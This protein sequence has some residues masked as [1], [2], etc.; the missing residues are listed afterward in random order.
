MRQRPFGDIAGT[1]FHVVNRAI[2][3]QLLFRDFGA[4]LAY[5]RLMA[6][7]LDR[8]P[9]DMFAFCLMPNHVHFLLRPTG[10]RDLVAFMQWLTS[11]HA[12]GVRRWSGTIGRGAV[13]QSRYWAS[14]VQKELYFCRVAR[15]IERNPVRASLVDRTHEWLWSS[16]SPVGAVQGIKRAE[17]PVPRPSHWRSFVEGVESQSDLDYI[18]LQTLNRLPIGEAKEVDAISAI[19]EPIRDAATDRK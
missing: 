17:W 8:V 11:R 5:T 14:P 10:E 9:I 3:G 12:M 4:Y 15:Y 18:R 2:E 6:R 13:Y 19:A 7:A 16:A 1:T